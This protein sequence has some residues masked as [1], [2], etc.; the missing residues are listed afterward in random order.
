MV[1]HEFRTP[2]GIT[3]SSAEILDDY[4]DRLEGSERKEHLQSI[5]KNTNRM[6]GLMEEVLLI[7]KFDV[8]K[9]EFKPQPLQL[10][11]FLRRLVDEVLSATQRRCPIS[12]SFG[13]LPETTLADESMLR[14][15]FNNLLT[16]AIKYSEPGSEVT[17]EVGG[18]GLELV[19]SI[20][21]RGIGIP[22]PDQ[23]WLFSAFHRG[24]NVGD[25]PGTGLGL[26]IVKRCIDLHGGRIQVQSALGA[27][28]NV[29]V[30]LPQLK[31]TSAA[32]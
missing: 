11:S 30:C 22:E 28:T 10:H 12:L 8:G 18:N 7:S 1:S 27:G 4:L 19:A 14:H 26:V 32:P 3:Q 17:F 20:R 24:S 9:M 13:N 31:V 21:D 5:Q 6:A 25:R 16:N 23:E 2:L 29:T 15:I